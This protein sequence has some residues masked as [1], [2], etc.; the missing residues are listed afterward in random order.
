MGL[1]LRLW[2]IVH[3]A[4]I[5]GDTLVYGDIASNWL[6][7]GIYGFTRVVRGVAVAPRPTLIRLPGYPLFLAACFRLFGVQEY[8]PVMLIQAVADL[9]SCALVASLA[10]R[11]FGRRARL[12]ALFLGCLC[13]FTASYVAVPLTETLSLFYIALAFYALER[14]SA[15]GAAVNRWLF[16]LAAAL[17]YAVLLRPEQGL[18]AAAVV[19]AMLWLVLSPRPA[20]LLRAAAPVVLAAILTLLPLVPWT[21]RN[22]RTFHVFQPL[23]PR[24]ATDPG[25]FI[26]LGFQRWYRTWGLD[27]ASTETA[28]WNYDGAPISVNDLPT[29]AF[30]SDD[31]YAAT[32]ALLDRYNE[33][34]NATPVF[35]AR[36]NALA[37]DRIHFNP[38]R[39]YVALPVGRVINMM[40]RPRTEYMPVPLE[41]WRFTNPL[42][43][44]FALAY[45]VLNLAYLAVAALGFRRAIHTARAGE[46]TILWA[47][48]AS[49][50]LRI[51][52]LLTIDNSEPRYTLEFFPVLI[53][54]AAA[55]FTMLP[56]QQQKAP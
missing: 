46:L 7:H 25:E 22:H 43:S 45:A 41:W 44:S 39:Y 49:I 12:P 8:V 52:L 11:L 17:A 37:T 47:M 40:F 53:V 56:K 21:I 35:D 4:R 15:A 30:D 26:P 36:F 48:A 2:F 51:V 10:D 27:F 13:P 24:F 54:F 3:H 50:L 29:R 28:Y 42:A 20:S 5:D 1:I 6:Q 33:T 32:A 14:W 19:P 16:V 55:C 18:L 38:L 31:Q 23:A 9:C 34:S